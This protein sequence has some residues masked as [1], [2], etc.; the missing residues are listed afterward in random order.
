MQPMNAAPKI[1]AMIL[2]YNVAPMLPRTVERIPD[3][4][5][6]RIFLTDDGST[7]DTREAA[8]ALGLEVIGH[9]P[10]RGYGGNVKQGFRHAFA[11]GADFVVEIHG[12]GAQFDPAATF[13]AMPLMRNGAD[14]IL[15]SRLQNKRQALR[16]GM[17]MV[18]FLANLGLSAVDRIVTG[19]PLTE[20]HTG[21]RIYSRR[22]YETLPWQDNSDDYLFS[23]EII[24]QAAYFGLDVREV[25][26][27]ADYN[28]D[29]TSISLGR[30]VKYAVTHLGTLRD[31]ALA[32]AGVANGSQ[33]PELPRA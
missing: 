26:V 20:F 31:L 16:N 12:D 9:T 21:F 11:A 23:F 27:Q 6:D 28:A 8:E 33:F 24:A 18:R 22:L 5:F 32:R 19:L 25:P 3:G 2:A 13:V 4:V 1:A 17:S 29:H 15:G 10:N 7:D 30:S 14:L